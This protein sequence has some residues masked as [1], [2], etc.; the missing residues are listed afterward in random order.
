MVDYGILFIEKRV[1]KDRHD[2]REKQESHDC[3]LHDDEDEAR[4]APFTP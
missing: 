1:I 4:V 2:D 3:F